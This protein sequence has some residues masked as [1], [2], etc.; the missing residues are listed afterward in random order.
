MD[1]MMGEK[2]TEYKKY[3]T[4]KQGNRSMKMDCHE[5]TE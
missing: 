2:R 3:A 1:G 5:C 4:E